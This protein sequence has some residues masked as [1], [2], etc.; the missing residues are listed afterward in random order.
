MNDVQNILL[1]MTG[2]MPVIV[3]GLLAVGCIALLVF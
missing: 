2:C 1:T 3:V